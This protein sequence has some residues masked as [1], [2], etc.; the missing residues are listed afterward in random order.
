MSGREL[1]ED[2]NDTYRPDRP[3]EQ[4]GH[5]L[6]LYPWQRTPENW[7]PK[8]KAHHPR[9]NT[10]KLADL[11]AAHLGQT[12]NISY[13]GDAITGTLYGINHKCRLEDVTTFTNLRRQYHPGLPS[14]HIS[15]L[16]WGDREFDP[17]TECSLDG[18]SE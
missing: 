9:R 11:N 3:W 8:D 1:D 4:A 6:Y 12:I 7:P 16:G 10:M 14:T 15:I 2:G 5:P 13:P 17:N 18:A